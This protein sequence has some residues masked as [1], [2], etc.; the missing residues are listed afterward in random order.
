MKL[1]STK[2]KLVLQ[3]FR[4]VFNSPKNKNES[5]HSFT[6]PDRVHCLV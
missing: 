6:F 1:I 5:I 3:D 4:H 2:N